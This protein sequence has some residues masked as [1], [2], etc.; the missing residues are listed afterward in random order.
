MYD[1]EPLLFSPPWGTGTF[2]PDSL[3]SPQCTSPDAVQPLW[4]QCRLSAVAKRKQW[5]Q[6]VLC[7]QQDFTIMSEGSC[8]LPDSD[9]I[10]LCRCHSEVSG[11]ASHAVMSAA[12]RRWGMPFLCRLFSSW[13]FSQ[14]TW[15]T[16]SHVRSAVWRPKLVRDSGTQFG[17]PTARALP[18]YSRKPRA[19][20][21]ANSITKRSF[22]S[23][24]FE[25]AS[26]NL[27]PGGTALQSDALVLLSLDE[28]QPEQCT[29]V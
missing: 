25:K 2:Q 18:G 16:A 4:E 15:K 7:Q 6:E 17:T 10:L 23:L 20:A 21:E 5:A 3:L 22:Y 11:G 29:G 24:E 27:V 13:W 26:T 9:H 8:V 14:T 19:V 28:P 12:V 1:T